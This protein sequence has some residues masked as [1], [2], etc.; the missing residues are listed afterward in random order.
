[1]S[2]ALQT[3]GEEFDCEARVS[4]SPATNVIWLKNCTSL[5]SFVLSDLSEVQ[6]ITALL[7]FRIDGRG[8]IHPRRTGVA[9]EKAGPPLP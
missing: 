2:V 8:F 7:N 4:Q 3:L 5:A 1:M 6:Q 9:R